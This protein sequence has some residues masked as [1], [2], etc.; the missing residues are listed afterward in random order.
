[1]GLFVSENWDHRLAV[2]FACSAWKYRHFCLNGDL[3]VEFGSAYY[4]LLTI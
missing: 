4:A 3:R 1:M 2:K